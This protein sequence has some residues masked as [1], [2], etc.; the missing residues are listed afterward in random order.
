MDAHGVDYT[1]CSRKRTRRWCSN[2]EV[3]AG[4]GSTDALL[5]SIHLGGLIAIIPSRIVFSVSVDNK[6]EEM[7]RL[8]HLELK[9][10]KWVMKEPTDL[11]EG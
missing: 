4:D 1:H 2:S 11:W 5:R 8:F 10:V 6:G 9:L 7:L 3:E